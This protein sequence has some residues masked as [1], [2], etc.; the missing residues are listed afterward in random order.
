VHVPIR[1]MRGAELELVVGQNGERTVVPRGERE[2]VTIEPL[3]YPAQV[4]GPIAYGQELGT[5]E[6]LQDGRRI[7]IVPLMAA[8]DVPAAD[9]AQRTKSWFSRPLGVVLAFVV[10]SG[11]VL[12]AQRRRRPNGSRRRRTREEAPVG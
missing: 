8:T 11:T 5:A 10:L 6:V 4:Q 12:L 9:L 2:R 7:A 3:E 1:Y